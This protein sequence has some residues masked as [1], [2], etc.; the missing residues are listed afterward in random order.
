MSDIP[1]DRH[2]ESYDELED[3]HQYR[4]GGFH[5]V[6][7]GD[8]LDGRFEVIH[9]LG[10]GAFGI[11]WLCLDTKSNKWHAVKV[12]RADHSSKDV[13][14]RVLGRITKRMTP[15]QLRKDYHILT[16]DE[17]FWV[18]GPNGRHP[19]LVMPV[20]GCDISIWR[21]LM[22]EPHQ[23]QSLRTAKEA[24]H[25]LMKGMR[26]L[27][28]NGICHGDFRPANILMQ[29]QSTDGISKAQMLE[30]IKRS[31]SSEW[32]EDLV[33][34]EPVIVDFGESFSIDFPPKTTGIPDTFAA[35]E[36]LFSTGLVGFGSDI[37][38]LACTIHQVWSDD[39]LFT[40]N[41]GVRGLVK[42]FELHLSPLP[43]P[44]RSALAS[45][46]HK[47]LVNNGG[48][49]SE[50]QQLLPA[51]WTLDALE[52]TKKSMLS[53]M[54]GYSETL[55]ACLGTERVWNKPLPGSD[56]HASDED[57]CKPLKYSY[58]RDEVLMFGDLLRKMLKYD[59]TERISID[60]VMKHEWVR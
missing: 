46:V 16:P 59:P 48:S 56:P 47:P 12:M 57:E 55:E 17:T 43:E 42:N 41:E 2:I 19:C 18:E 26:F 39:P 36:I 1:H 45:R 6:H 54:P 5:P 50:T 51:T 44:F 30:R 28:Q 4:P 49:D 3:V 60:E 27:H 14:G 10:Q 40:T 7:L 23:E 21:L 25:K 34:S 11:V 22:L 15:M 31:M 8:I 33:G 53:R 9:K 37:W 38:A 35:P 13:E 52:R 20:M 58:P 24:C 32:C 29:L